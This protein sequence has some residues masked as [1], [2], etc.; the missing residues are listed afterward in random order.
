[1]A[2]SIIM[3]KA[4]MAMETGTIIEWKVAVGDAIET[5]D[6]ILEIETD[7]VAMP[8][9]AECSGYLL[10]IVRQE[11]E[12][13]PVTETIGW[14]GARGEAVPGGESAAGAHLSAGDVAAVS[15][16]EIAT[17]GVTDGVGAGGGARPREGGATGSV[18]GSATGGAESI[19]GRVKATPA[20]RRRADAAGIAL[21]AVTPTGP[22]GEVRATDVERALGADGG[23]GLRVTPLAKEVARQ[24]NLSL[25]GVAGSGPE[26]RIRRRDV[27]AVI[28]TRG[29]EGD[30][31]TATAAADRWMWG[32]PPAK[33]PVQPL[34][35]D[36]RS[37]ITGMR[38]V[39]AARMTESHLT[40]PPVTLNAT[41]T[42]DRL[43]ALRAALNTRHASRDEGAI[44]FSINDFLLA[45][46]AKAVRACPW[47][48]VSVDGDTLVRH[49]AVNLGMAVALKE[50]LVVPVIN[51]AD[52]LTLSRIAAAARDLGT[53]ARD[54]SLTP[55]EMEGG[56]VTLS[57]LGMY[58]ITTFTPIIN[59][60]QAAIVGV[61]T[62]RK[63]LYRVATD[64]EDEARADRAVGAIPATDGGEPFF[65]AER[66]RIDLSVTI[67]HRVIDG[68]QGALFL[69]ELVSLV[70]HPMTILV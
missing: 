59:A 6:E 26:G 63:E 31:P 7:K 42:V 50:G 24:A 58:G 30:I 53:R 14:I 66:A 20:A 34:P 27:E 23:A 37:P 11:G 49:E 38:R 55:A 57:N 46:T 52:T 35:G 64:A 69:R 16:G 22:V 17:G 36:S 32:I 4:G 1:M 39:I 15:A 44:I 41:A 18:V 70:E 40:M 3:P 56:T 19:G 2:T 43:L 61:G 29:T 65:V 67:D 54:R 10:A 25:E 68:A 62:V 51:D 45:A 47:V 60:P 5:G 21:G 8:V 28:E 9:E 33:T 48:R 13:V 12:E